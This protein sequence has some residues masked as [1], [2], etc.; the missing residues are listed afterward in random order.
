MVLAF[1]LSAR[2][3]VGVLTPEAQRTDPLRACEILV[4]GRL[5]QPLSSHRR[6]EDKS[7]LRM[8]TRLAKLHENRSGF[9]P[10]IWTCSCAVFNDIS[11]I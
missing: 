2:R 11:K 8:I 10:V 1:R 6:R 9:S 3:L 4:L 7:S 5:S